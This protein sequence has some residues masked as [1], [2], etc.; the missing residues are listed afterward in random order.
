MSSPPPLVTLNDL[1]AFFCL[2]RRRIYLGALFGALLLIGLRLSLVPSYEAKATF[3]EKGEAGEELSL[4]SL[5]LA[6][7][8]QGNSALS[9]FKSRRLLGV[10]CREAGL[11]AKILKKEQQTRVFWRWMQNLRIQ[12]QHWIDPYRE[13]RS[14]Q[15]EKLRCDHLH[16]EGQKS[17]HL[18]LTVID[19]TQLEIKGPKGR[20][21]GIIHL[22]SPFAFRGVE[23]TLHSSTCL[24]RGEGYTL[25]L[26][27]LDKTV[28]N[29]LDHF[30][31]SSKAEDMS[32]F[33]LSFVHPDRVMAITFLDSLMAAYK[34]YLHEQNSDLSSAQLAYLGN[35]RQEIEGQ[36]THTLAREAERASQGFSDWGFATA[37]DE[38][39]F[40]ITMQG[41]KR[42]RLLEIELER[43]MIDRMVDGHLDDVEVLVQRG[44]SPNLKEM[45]QI[46]YRLQER[47]DLLQSVLSNGSDEKTWKKPSGHGL[48]C[49]IGLEKAN[50]LLADCHRGLNQTTALIGQY[51]YVLQ[52]MDASRF[53]LSSLSAS[54]TDQV[55][56]EM[57]AETNRLLL[58][59]SD[60]SYL[61][62]KEQ[63]R[64]EEDIQRQRG[65]LRAHLEEGKAL[66]QKKCS[67]YEQQMLHLNQTLLGLVERRIEAVEAQLMNYLKARLL[68]LDLERE[69]TDAQLL[70]LRQALASTPKRLSQERLSQL[71]LEHGETLLTECAK[72]IEAK[73]IEHHLKSFF[74]DPVDKAAASVLPRSPQLPL[75]LVLG[76]SLGAGLV[77]LGLT[78]QFISKES[79][80]KQPA[81]SES[82]ETL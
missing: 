71:Q 74:A 11:Q 15:T 67:A 4:F 24:Q 41:E 16:Y 55:T 49:T 2:H 1:W 70:S 82:Q 23:L 25:V 63:E 28:D 35:K 61:T 80:A 69:Q 29:I 78:A 72:L 73:G 64:M 8:G 66:L 43:Q 44:R 9:L 14:L 40:L 42:Q 65:H 26:E 48:Y 68:G 32:Y 47:R 31:I 5:V 77:C 27:P 39:D 54:V 18:Q 22:G 57:L 38:V 13:L 21:W 59:Y 45:T 51:D 10:A 33:Y 46:W 20:D 36:L 17:L 30:E 53:A 60:A 62:G 52:Q 50:D 7:G 37:K 56:A 34:Q 75:A 19:E 76:A 3:R 79:G 81:G 6:G 12:I 58:A